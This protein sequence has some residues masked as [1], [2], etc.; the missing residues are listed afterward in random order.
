MKYFISHLFSII[1]LFSITLYPQGAGNCVDFGSSGDKYI[2]C[3]SP[4]SLEISSAITVEAWIY[5]T[6]FND[7][8]EVYAKMGGNKS[9]SYSGNCYSHSIELRSGRIYY[10]ISHNGTSYVDVAGS[11]LST[12]I[13]QHVVLTFDGT[14]IKGY[15]N[16]KLDANYSSAGSIYT[17]T[18]NPFLIGSYMYY[19]WPF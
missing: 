17:S 13:W 14:N 7:A 18:S 15:V 8:N 19:P 2:H 11:T 3:G 10:R 9:G 6:T 16:G 1:S 4:T 12:N 5:P